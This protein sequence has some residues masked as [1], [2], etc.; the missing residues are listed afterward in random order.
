MF[1]CVS[2]FIGLFFRLVFQ[3]DRS[4]LGFFF[5]L[6]LFDI[7]FLQS[8]F[9]NIVFFF[10]GDFKERDQFLVK[11]FGLIWRESF[12]F[13][14][15]GIFRVNYKLVEWGIEVY[16][17]SIVGRGR[18]R[19]VLLFLLF[20]IRYQFGRFCICFFCCG[21]QVYFKGRNRGWF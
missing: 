1:L 16:V 18:L 9:R 3:E 5:Y 4:V 21:E 11:R 6:R 14:N 20:M 2:R 15:I 17:I 13:F 12:F 19:F 7:Q 8:F 10:I